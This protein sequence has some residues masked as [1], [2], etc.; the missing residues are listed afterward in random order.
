MP[1]AQGLPAQTTHRYTHVGTYRL[2]I[3]DG[4]SMLLV[5]GI[6]AGGGGGLGSPNSVSGNG[7]NGGATTFSRVSGS[8]KTVLLTANGGNGG[9]EGG[10]TTP[11]T[12]GAAQTT[13][14]RTAGFGQLL[15]T[16][17]A[18]GNSG[19]SSSTTV[20]QGGLGGVTALGR[21]AGGTR[22]LGY[23]GNGGNAVYPGA[24]GA[25]GAGGSQ[26]VDGS[27]LFECGGGGGGSGQYVAGYL[28]VHPGETYEIVVGS[29]GSGGV[30]AG[31]A[32][33]GGSGGNGADGAVIV[34]LLPARSVQDGTFALDAQRHFGAAGSVATGTFSNPTVET[35]I[36]DVTGFPVQDGQNVALTYS[37]T[38][39]YTTVLAGGGTG[40]LTL[41]D[42]VPASASGTIAFD[43]TA[44]LAAFASAL[45]DTGTGVL[46]AGQYNTT[47]VPSFPGT[48]TLHDTGAILLLNGVPQHRVTYYHPQGEP[49]NLL[50]ETFA[51]GSD[52]ATTGS[53]T[54]GDYALT[55]A[56]ASG[57][58]VGQG[59]AVA[60]A[61][62]APTISA[63][64]AA[65]AT[66]NG[67]S[68]STTIDYAV[69]AMDSSGGVTA[70]FAFSLTDANATLSATNYVALAV[71][72][73]SG[74]SYYAWWRTSTNGT[75]PS[76]TGYIGQTTG[77]TLDDTGLAV[78]TPPIGI[79]TSAPS[80]ALGDQLLSQV[81]AISGSV[82]TLADAAG[83]TV[84]SAAVNHDDTAA[85]RQGIDSAAGVARCLFPDSG[86]KYRIHSALS[87]GSNSHL[88]IDGY[89]YLADL[90]SD[91]ILLLPQNSS[92][93]VIE[94][95]GT[96]DGNKTANIGFGTNGSGG[97]VT[98][99]LDNG[100]GQNVSNVRVRGLTIKDCSD[101]PINFAGTTNAMATDITA[102]SCG[103]PLQISASATDTHFVRCEHLG[104]A[105]SGIAVYGGAAHCSVVD[106]TGSGAAYEGIAVLNDSNQPT[107]CKDINIIR[108]RYYNNNNHGV[109]IINNYSTA[110]SSYHKRVLV[111]G[112][113]SD[114][115]NTGNNNA[116]AGINVQNVDRVRIIGC[117]VHDNGSTTANIETDGVLIVSSTDVRVEACDIGN[118]IQSG[119]F[120]AG[121]RVKGTANTNVDISSNNF[122]DDQ[123]THT[124]NDH[125][126]VD[127]GTQI[128]VKG[129]DFDANALSGPVGIASGVTPVVENN[130]GY[131][132]VG[133]LT[134]PTIP[135][136]ATAIPNPF[137]YACMVVVTGGTAV[138]IFIGNSA[139]S[140][141]A[142]G[143]A[144]GAVMLAAG[145]Y[146][147]L[148]DYTAAPTWNWWGL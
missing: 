30:S 79:P 23:G 61:G 116:A 47:A 14:S 106:C 35:N 126:Y 45:G 55:V 114:G 73:V 98:P 129:N 19:P 91:A 103:E 12:A 57:W 37:G 121:V 34:H 113:E 53:I 86:G 64:T 28:S 133:P 112:V 142:T 143:L 6:G 42:N 147:Q 81:T 119:G 1:N 50:R 125:V 141:V 62:A 109:D 107:P 67:T 138:N 63:P 78:L 120:A 122:Y 3:P 16:G 97:I 134:A 104:S 9:T 43:D 130:A 49:V 76:T 46:P 59:I 25:G 127:G 69:A 38:T 89:L 56:S 132:P 21:Q 2:T 68:G 102:T 148:G 136:A 111:S 66:A 22:P 40:T 137:P 36:V 84:T 105:D 135:S 48:A 44:A 83:S 77:I 140:T 31:I 124:T 101:W 139:S 108:G 74:A 72:A 100:T 90:S 115:N 75:S 96:L 39:L 146:I 8:T 58:S 93:I 17:P 118:T 54:S 145:Q 29:G 7:A 131:N 92:N 88:V 71:T 110:A 70:S 10:A 65:T 5:E 24:G 80:A 27:T 95:A 11:G 99:F 33:Y 144:S 41:A 4:V 60:N 87:V 82:L 123:S 117:N 52:T 18:G 51:S 128:S 13:D 32:F 94:G 85:A 15:L 20:S 26:L